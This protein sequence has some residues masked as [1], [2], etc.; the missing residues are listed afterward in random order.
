MNCIL[1]DWGDTLMRVFPE[2]NGA[3]VN[4]PRVE[5]MPGAVEVLANLQPFCKLAIATNARDSDESEIWAALMRAELAD[6][7][8]KVYCF[9]NIGHPK[10]SREFFATVLEDLKLPSDQVIMVGDS[11][12]ADILGASQA[13]LRAVWL[14]LMT[15]EDRTNERCKTVHSLLELPGVLKSWRLI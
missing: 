12:E 7:L 11:W 8:D 14:N 6:Y 4:W 5:A 9:S 1:F 2:F 3:M 10:P 15:P 13:G